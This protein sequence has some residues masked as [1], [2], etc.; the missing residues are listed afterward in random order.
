MTSSGGAGQSDD[1]FVVDT[2]SIIQVRQIMAQQ[3]TSKI[4]GVYAKLIRLGQNGLLRFPKSVI[5]EIEVRCD[6]GCRGTRF[7]PFVGGCM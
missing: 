3:T 2:S 5:D 6:E 4:T 7:R 1:T